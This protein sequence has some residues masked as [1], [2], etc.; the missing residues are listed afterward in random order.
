MTELIVMSQTK[1]YK[2]HI[3]SYTI[4]EYAVTW[5]NLWRFFERLIGFRSFLELTTKEYTISL[6]MSEDG[7][8]VSDI[9]V[10]K[11]EP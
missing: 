6:Y 11:K 9:T 4:E 2:Y 1:T 7:N 10:T 5:G 3:F 8:I